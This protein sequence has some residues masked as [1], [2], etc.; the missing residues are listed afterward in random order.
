VREESDQAHEEAAAAR[1]KCYV[2]LKFVRANGRAGVRGATE[3]SVTFIHTAD[4]QLGKPFA[5]VSDN[6]KRALLR[7]ARVQAVRRIAA[8][9]I[10]RNAEFVVVSGDLFDSA[11]P[12]NST[13]SA[14][15]DAIG[16]M[17]VPVF[18]IP[19]NHDH[20]GPGSVWHQTFFQRERQQLAPNLHVLLSNDPVEL[21]GAVLFPCPLLR[22]HEAADPTACLRTMANLDRYGT[23]A[24]IVV[25]HGSTMDFGD[26]LADEE[27]FSSAA[28]NRVDLPGLRGDDFDYVALGDWHGMKQI[29]AKAWYCGTPEPDR[30]PKGG[31][32]AQ[33]HLLLVTAA[34][35]EAP[36]VE[37]ISTARMTWK[38]LSFAFGAAK[39]LTQLAS[40]VESAIG[41][42]GVNAA[43]LRLHLSG[44]LSMDDS[45]ALHEL[46]ESWRARL[47]RLKLHDT[48][49]IA[50]ADAELQSLTASAE[51]PLVA[52]VATRLAGA[53]MTGGPDAAIAQAAL[54][55][56]YH[57]TSAA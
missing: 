3:M 18:V 35:G 15:C 25:A 37:G 14:A 2:P 34:R 21:H 26:A 43:L 56:L 40:D 12:L 1:G 39:S 41:T 5:G 33:G 27:D 4:W 19:G 52:R 13:V 51:N 44:V 9:V 50:P 16:E 49:V 48:T 24:R 7:D 57:A 29:T 11:T 6:H 45:R 54:R 23:K 22:R 10:Q 31:E 53:M 20:G 55:E 47:I 32:H 8:E 30:F 46:F 17:K 42:T 38:E 36:V 28:I